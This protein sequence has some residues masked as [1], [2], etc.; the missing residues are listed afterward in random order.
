MN[1]SAVPVGTRIF[2]DANVFVYH[3][4]PHP[5]FGPTCTDLL[6]RIERNELAGFTSAFILSDLVHR[7]MTL[8]AMDRFGWPASGLAHR[9]KRHPNDVQQLGRYRQAIDEIRLIGV[10]VLA[11]AGH[12]VSRAADFSQQFGLL[13]NDAL[14]VAV[15][16]DTGLDQLASGDADFDRVSGIARWSPI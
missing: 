8:E 11:V 6:E 12:H 14:T 10:H 4:M 1:L 5:A 16:R 15:M 13:T 9:L 3:F 7:L 2:V